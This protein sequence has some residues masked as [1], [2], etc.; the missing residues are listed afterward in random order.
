MLQTDK[1][2]QQPT[3]A[4][5]LNLTAIIMTIL[6]RDNAWEQIYYYPE[7]TVE[8]EDEKQEEGPTQG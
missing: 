7:V 3:F 1:Q 6:L 4:G 2:K 5:I 8:A